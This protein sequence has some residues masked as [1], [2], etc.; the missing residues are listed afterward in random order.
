M[1]A[2]AK[3]KRP[4]ARRNQA[5]PV[6]TLLIGLGSLALVAAAVFAF[7]AKGATSFTPEGTGAPKLKADK[8][9][10]DLGE[11]KLGQTVEVSF[12]ITNVGDQPLRFRESPYVEVVEGC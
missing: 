2:Y 12:E 5:P 7:W 11:V 9:Q 1:P 4:T 8:E 10:M 6:V 3:G